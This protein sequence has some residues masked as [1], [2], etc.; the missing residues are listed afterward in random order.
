M[1]TLLLSYGVFASIDYSRLDQEMEY[2]RK[3]A[4]KGK[5]ELSQKEFQ[6]ERAG[7]KRSLEEDIVD[8]DQLYFS[9][10][11]STKSAAPK[12]DN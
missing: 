7:L 9:D 8:L 12:K 5:E 1:T 6:R 4:F 3:N 2:L 10:S 11:I